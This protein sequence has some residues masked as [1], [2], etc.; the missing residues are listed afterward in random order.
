[1]PARDEQH[2]IREV[3]PVGQPRRQRMARQVVDAHQRQPARSGDRLCRH[4]ARQ[5][6]TDQPGPG[7]D[8]DQFDV[9]QRHAGLVQRPGDAEVQAF[10]MGAGGDLGDHAAEAGVQRGLLEDH[11][12]MD[13]AVPADDG[14]G[15]F[16][17]A[18]LDP[19]TKPAHRFYRSVCAFT[20]RRVPLGAW[21][22]NNP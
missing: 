17:T 7:G 9:V 16:V 22:R 6:T 14:G 4:H 8:R 15:G 13:G 5:Y 11:R 3:Q 12:G 20:R 19:Q 2:Q 21:L 10:G 18:A 1:M